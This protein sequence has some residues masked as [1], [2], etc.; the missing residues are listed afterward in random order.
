MWQKRSEHIDP[1]SQTHVVR[2]HDPERSSDPAHDH[3]IQ[4]AIG[5]K[6]CPHCGRPHDEQGAAADPKAIVQAALHK[7]RRIGQRAAAYAKRHGVAVKR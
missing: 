7:Q 6:A 1:I 5:L 3:I 4:I 2:L